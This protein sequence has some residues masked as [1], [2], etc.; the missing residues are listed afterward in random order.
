MYF[1]GRK[2]GKGIFIYEAGSKS[3]DRPVN[4]SAEGILTRHKLEPK[5][6]LTDEDVLMR[7]VT[8]FVNE[9]VL[10]LQEKILANPVN[11]FI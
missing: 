1:T 8:R 3:T 7:M 5:L 9:A 11:V 4:T 6:P 2:S 10:C